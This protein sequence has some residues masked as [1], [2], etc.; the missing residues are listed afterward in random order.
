MERGTSS[1]LPS[2]GVGLDIVSGAHHR[3]RPG[4]PQQLSPGSQAPP[5]TLASG[6]GL[7]DGGGGGAVLNALELTKPVGGGVPEW[8]AGGGRRRGGL[9]KRWVDAMSEGESRRSRWCRLRTVAGAALR[10]PTGGR[11]TARR[12][13][14]D[15]HEGWG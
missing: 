4:R 7:D 2:A 13:R 8:S 1:T 10:H 14:R 9:F 12:A 15:T 3:C 6:L 11:W 5:G